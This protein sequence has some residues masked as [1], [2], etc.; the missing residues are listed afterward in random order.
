MAA[1]LAIAPSGPA[2]FTLRGVLDVSTAPLLERRLA[3]MPLDTSVVLDLS[4]VEFMDSIGLASI[5]RVAENLDAMVILE[6]PT[7]Q[8]ARFLDVMD[9]TWRG[10]ALVRPRRAGGPRSAAAR[11]ATR[12]KPLRPTDPML[13]WS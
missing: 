10:H 8:V 13:D 4:G 11:H 12:A 5:G 9:P 6:A 2:R 1:E 3:T 7:P